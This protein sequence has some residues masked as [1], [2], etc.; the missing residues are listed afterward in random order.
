MIYVCVC[1][2]RDRDTDTPS[3]PT[4]AGTGLDGSQELRTQSGFPSWV[5]GTQVL[6]LCEVTGC[7]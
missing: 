6:E 7:D 1:V 5:A 4:K 3:G 2:E